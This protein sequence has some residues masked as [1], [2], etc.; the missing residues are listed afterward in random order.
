MSEESYTSN[1]GLLELLR[2]DGF[3]MV[4]KRLIQLLGLGEAIILADFASCQIQFQDEEG[5]WFST[6]KDIE[7]AT[8]FSEY[9]QNKIINNLISVG[10]VEKER[11]GVPAKNYYR[12]DTRVLEKILFEEPSEIESNYL[13]KE[14]EEDTLKNSGSQYLKNSGTKYPKNSGTENPKNS[15]TIYKEGKRYKEGVY[16]EE[17]TFINK[18]NLETDVSF[19]SSNSFIPDKD[20]NED[21]S[22]KQKKKPLPNPSIK[23]R[24]GDGEPVLPPGDV[25]NA[26]LYW[27]S[28]PNVPKLRLNKKTKTLSSAQKELE[29]LLKKYPF[30]VVKG[31]MDTYSKLLEE[32]ANVKPPKGIPL[33]VSLA[34]FFGF[35]G[36]S[37]QR[38]ELVTGE[39]VK[40]CWFNECLPGK[41]PIKAY[42]KNKVEDT[43][44]KYTESLKK[45]WMKKFFVKEFTPAQEDQFRKAGSMLAEFDK[46]TRRKMPHMYVYPSNDPTPY[47]EMLFK[48]LGDYFEDG[49]HIGNLCSKF[50]FEN[51]FPAWLRKKNAFGNG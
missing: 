37:K 4:N 25:T 30:E 36:F 1:I 42:W 23:K 50:T 46:K 49:F 48:A 19:P 2:Q 22:I 27:N 8:G 45:M 12:V 51:I 17:I 47:V 18:G 5:W 43:H 40:F 32:K 21:D 6:H 20:S 7:K 9:K 39:K 28:L 31:T 16:K 14:R 33:R 29:S 11:R 38:I 13:S 35:N 24:M 26:I 41:D 34:E 10:I 15:G 44:P 3:L